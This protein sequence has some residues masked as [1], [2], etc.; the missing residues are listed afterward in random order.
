MLRKKLSKP[1][2]SSKG[3]IFV[4]GL[5]ALVLVGLIFLLVVMGTQHFLLGEVNTMVQE[6]DDFDSNTKNITSELYNKNNVAWD[7]GFALLIAGLMIGF[8]LAGATLNNNPI[9]LGVVIIMMLFSVYAGMYIVNIYEDVSD[10][11]TDTLSFNSEFPKAHA[12]MSNLVLVIIG[13]ITLLGL[14]VF[15]SN[16]IGI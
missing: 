10:D 9:V 12:I 6:D 16:N 7:N 14:G 4:I 15:T 11:T 13:G 8:F 5:V 3:N 1:L 2:G